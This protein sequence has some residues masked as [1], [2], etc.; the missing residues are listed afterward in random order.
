MFIQQKLGATNIH[1]QK[2]LWMRIHSMCVKCIL[3]LDKE[4]TNILYFSQRTT[5]TQNSRDARSITSDDVVGIVLCETKSG[6]PLRGLLS[7]AIDPMACVFLEHTYTQTHAY[8]VSSIDRI[9][10]RVATTNDKRAAAESLYEV[11]RQLAEL[12]SSPS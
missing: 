2:S 12:A 9:V 7:H 8:A 4:N 1:K 3:H 5:Y 11:V 6:L 10:C